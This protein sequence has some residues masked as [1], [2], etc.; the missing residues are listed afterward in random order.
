MRGMRWRGVDILA[1]ARSLVMDLEPLKLETKVQEAELDAMRPLP[2]DRRGDEFVSIEQGR[3]RTE[4]MMA[5]KSRADTQCHRIGWLDS[6]ARTRCRSLAPDRGVLREIS[7]G[8]DH[9][10]HHRNA[11][12]RGNQPLRQRRDLS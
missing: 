10:C 7:Y 4:R 12:R 2:M 3:A 6:R 5:A 11:L 9:A 1:R 8:L